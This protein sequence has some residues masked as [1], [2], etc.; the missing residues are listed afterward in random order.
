MAD[1][2]DTLAHAAMQSRRSAAW[3]LRVVRQATAPRRQDPPLLDVW[4]RTQPKYRRRAILLLLVNCILFAGLGCFAFWLRTGQPIPFLEPNYWELFWRSFNPTAERQVTLIDFLIA[5]IN[6]QQAPMQI[7]VLGLL[8]ASFVSIPILIAMLYRLPAALIFTFILAFVA[9]FPWLALTVTLACVLT[10][11]RPLQF[12]F[13]FATALIALIPAALY[14]YNATRNPPPEASYAT[15]IESAALYAPWVLALLASCLVMGIVLLIARIVNYRP[16]AIS[17]LLAVLFAVPV[18]LFEAKVGRDELHYRLLENQY[19][20]RSTYFRD[21]DASAVIRALAEDV[22]KKEMG[23]NDPTRPPRSLADIERDIKTLWMYQLDPMGVEDDELNLFQRQVYRVVR[24]CDK[25]CFDF[26]R[27]RYVPN[28]LY[29]KGRAQDTRIDIETFRRTGDLR[30]YQDF[31]NPTSAATWEPL[32]TQYPECP[33]SGVAMFRSAQLAARAGRIDAALELLNTMIDRFAS[34][35]AAASTTPARGRTRLE[36]APPTSTLDLQTRTVVREARGFRDLL[37][38]NRDPHL[39]APPEIAA[40]APLVEFLRLDPRHRQ[41]A[42]NLRELLDRYPTARLR[43]NLLL[44]L[45]KTT[46]E[47][48]ASLRIDELKRFIRMFEGREG[49]ATGPE[50]RYDAVPEA[51]YRLAE[52]YLGDGRPGDA[53]ATFEEVVKRYPDSLWAEAAQKQVTSLGPLRVTATNSA[54]GPVP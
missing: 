53:L 35:A 46:T 52:A 7:V 11:L 37:Q 6:V 49:T 43:D 51:Y 3:L 36:K 38:F 19:G 16:D 10:R 26:P 47:R 29:I 15:P 1:A 27:S 21:R 40:D 25:F 31:P 8:L 28:V 9:V 45:V 33:A 17:P 23:R 13:R 39:V 50:L 32:Y 20:P 34:A 2:K 30:F 42:A 48:S 18:V 41:Y 24:A 22:W 4:S 54:R 5:P 12:N 44:E 14:L